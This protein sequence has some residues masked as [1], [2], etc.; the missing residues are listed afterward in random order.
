MAF[1]D[2]GPAFGIGLM[3]RFSGIP[4]VFA[5]FAQPEAAGWGSGSGSVT[6][7]G[8]TYT[9]SRTLNMPGSITTSA[10]YDPD[11]HRDQAGGITFEFQL[12]GT[13]DPFTENP[14]LD[15]LAN[16]P[17]RAD[18]NYATA[19]R[20]IDADDITWSVS[21]TANWPASGVLHSGIEAMTYSGKTALLFTNITRGRWGSKP[22]EHRVGVTGVTEV[23]SGGIITSHVTVW[24]GRIA[25]F[26]IVRGQHVDG[27]LVP[28]ATAIEDTSVDVVERYVVKDAKQNGPSTAARVICNSLSGLQDLQVAQRLPTATAG[29]ADSDPRRVRIDDTINQISWE[30]R[31]F[32]NSKEFSFDEGVITQRLQRDLGGGVPANVVAGWYSPLELAEFLTFTILQQNDGPSWFSW[33][34]GGSRSRIAFTA[35]D[36]QLSVLVRFDLNAVPTQADNDWQVALV[37]YPQSATSVLRGAGFDE[38]VETVTASLDL[39]SKYFSTTSA[40]ASRVFPRLYIPAADGETPLWLHA[41]EGIAFDAAPGWLDDAG[42]AINGHVRIGDLE[43]V[44]FDA[45]TSLGGGAYQL[46]IVSRATLG[47]TL[48]EIYIERGE[49]PPAAVQGLAFPATSWLRMLLYLM[50]GGSGIDGLNH[51]TWDKG[52]VGSG[53]YIQADLVDDVSFLELVYR[54]GNTLRD[55]AFFQPANLRLVMESDGLLANALIRQ[56]VGQLSIAAVTKAMEAER[57]AAPISLSVADQHP[58]G[59]RRA[60]NSGENMISNAL[61]VA[62][63]WDHAKDQPKHTAREREGTSIASYGMRNRRTVELRGISSIEELISRSQDLAAP[64]F[65]VRGYPRA[66]FTIPYAFAKTWDAAMLDMA[67]VSDDLYPSLSVGGAAASATR[68]FDGALAQLYEVRRILPASRETR[69]ERGRLAFFATNKDGSRH[70]YWA[71]SAYAHTIVGAVATCTDHELS[72]NETGVPRDVEWFD[73]DRAGASPRC[74]VYPVGDYASGVLATVSSV[75]LGAA[76]ASAIT[77][78]A[79]LGLTAPCIIEPAPYDDASLT[80]EQ[81]HYAYMSDGDH[82]LDKAVGT[83][84]PYKYA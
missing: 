13:Q 62:G 69:A 19:A 10:R 5:D 47:S 51:A 73:E 25:H 4:Y 77:F 27:V 8:E 2:V 24:E 84:V 76:D 70:S 26:W 64:Y 46:D 67:L 23:A 53:I 3:V 12:P 14:W 28:D 75:T 68:G 40:E 50:L 30:W 16:D 80:D 33:S 15:L 9:W 42:D 52:W 56:K 31:Y 29:F 39:T 74:Y 7:D 65:A 79:A 34:G 37:L 43:C 54:L 82:K 36:D 6:I 72:G 38:T 63:A 83:D 49:E 35:V 55:W 22:I 59:N 81:R 78:S 17:F 41:L 20:T 32:N 61:D 44:E 57:T 71:P 66:I 48:Q 58:D 21:G 45:V 1:S 60:Y 18:Q 11:R